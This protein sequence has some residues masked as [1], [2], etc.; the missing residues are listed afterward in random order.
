[1]W[2]VEVDVDVFQV[3][4]ILYVVEILIGCRDAEDAQSSL[5]PKNLLH[6]RDLLTLTLGTISGRLQRPLAANRIRSKHA[7]DQANKNIVT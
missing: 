4:L 7:R 1:M 6:K 2:R 5:Q 3:I